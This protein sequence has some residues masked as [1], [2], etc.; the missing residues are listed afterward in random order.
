MPARE[1]AAI[2]H[3]RG[4]RARGPA[5]RVEPG[6]HGPGLIGPAWRQ[7]TPYGA[8]RGQ[9]PPSWP[10][11]HAFLG[12]RADTSTGLDIIG[13]RQYDPATGRFLSVD[14]VLDSSSAQTL[15]GYNYAAG[16][17]VTSCDPTGLCRKSMP[18]QPPVGCPRYEGKPERQPVRQSGSGSHVTA[19]QVKGQA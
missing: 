5:D 11:T 9:A 10:D 8:P 13:A 1:P 6:P 14:P 18:D 3:S 19:G 15:A 2:T 17:P 4:V 12:K 7:Y 16:N